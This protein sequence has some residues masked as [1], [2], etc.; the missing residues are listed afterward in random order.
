MWAWW[1]LGH[2]K[3]ATVGVCF[4]GSVCAASVDG[5]WAERFHATRSMLGYVGSCGM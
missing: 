2:H 5:V 4:L 3:I 1:F